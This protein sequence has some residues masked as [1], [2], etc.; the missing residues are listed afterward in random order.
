LPAL[1]FYLASTFLIGASLGVVGSRNP[2]YA[3]LFLVLAFVSAAVLWLLAGAE[4]LAMALV[5][6]Y[7]GAVMVLFLFVIMMIDVRL[8]V[9]HRSFVRYLPLGVVVAVAMAVQIIAALRSLGHSTT[10][11]LPAGSNT[12]ALGTL[13]YTR[14]L[15]PFEI[16]GLILLLAIVAA[17]ALTLRRREGT[18]HHD[19]ARQ[20][21][22]RKQDR[23]RLWRLPPREAS[24]E[25]PSASASAREDS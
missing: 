9:L 16:A 3:A 20:V 25:Q 11:A 10:Q 8:A 1:P 21:L 15:Y 24:V 5:V 18:R 19:P 13:I 23:L 17:I 7:V 4:F 12:E 14:Y 2:V 22:V 6:V